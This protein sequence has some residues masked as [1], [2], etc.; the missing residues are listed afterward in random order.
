MSTRFTVLLFLLL[1]SGPASGTAA[2]N[3]RIKHGLLATATHLHKQSTVS[4][5]SDRRGEL[6]LPQKVSWRCRAHAEVSAKEAAILRLICSHP[7][8]ATPRFAETRC[9]EDSQAAKIAF[10]RWELRLGCA[11]NAAR[12]ER[13]RAKSEGA[14]GTE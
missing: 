11:D 13:I 5:S 8:Q 12:L 4:L 10:A 7:Q 1:C 9:T 2:A 3:Y 6:P 14:K